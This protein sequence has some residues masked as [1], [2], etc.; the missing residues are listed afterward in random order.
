MP[1][2]CTED[3]CDSRIGST[4]SKIDWADSV[5]AHHSLV[6]KEV[7]NGVMVYRISGSFFFG[8]ADKLESSLKRLK[9][10]P[11]CYINSPHE[12]SSGDE[13]RGIDK[14]SRLKRWKARNQSKKVRIPT[15]SHPK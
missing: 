7:P 9:Q 2:F 4:L 12:K 10:E 3:R 6:G 1:C 8:A 11:E 5:S 14:Y 13:A 15:Q